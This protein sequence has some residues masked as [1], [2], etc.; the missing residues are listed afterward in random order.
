[1]PHELVNP[2]ELGPTV[3]FSHATVAAAGRTVYL[4]GQTAQDSTGKIVGD[5]I[6]SQFDRALSNVVI[7]LKAAGGEPGDI[8]SMV[9]YTTDMSAY[10]G[11]LKDLGRAYQ[12]HLGR[13]YP[14][15]ALLG[16]SE[17]FDPQA[18]VE[19]IA[20]AVIAP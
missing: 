4:G 7:A 3:G 11:A 9:I 13:H 16:V 19:I 20:T 10:R 1:M 2:P 15:M 5:D 8:V 14:A 17:L 6:V 12:S 18:L